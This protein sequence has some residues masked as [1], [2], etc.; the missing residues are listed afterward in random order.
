MQIKKI[1]SIL[2]SCV[3]LP[4]VYSNDKSLQVLDEVHEQLSKYYYDQ[5]IISEKWPSIYNECR[6]K[7]LDAANSQKGF[8]VIKKALEKLK[9]SH[10]HLLTPYDKKELE[11]ME[12]MTFS[13]SGEH[14]FKINTNGQEW[15]L[16]DDKSNPSYMGYEVLEVNGNPL[17]GLEH[18][19]SDWSKLKRYMDSYESIDL[20]LKK[21][22]KKRAIEI[23]RTKISHNILKRSIGF[24]DYKDRLDYQLINEVLV[25]RVEI[26]TISVIQK[27]KKLIQNNRNTKGIVLDLRDNPGGMGML[28][29]ALALEFAKED[30]SLGSQKGG[31]LE[32]NYVV[33][34]QARYYD[35]KVAVIINRNSASTSEI[36]ARGLQ[37]QK[38]ARLFGERTAGMALPSVIKKLS[39]DCVFQYPIGDFLDESGELLEGK[40]VEP[41]E[42]VSYSQE[43]LLSGIDAQ[44]KAALNWIRSH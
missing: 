25:L 9:V 29:C 6:I 15:L 44:L 13:S 11:W 41:D 33:V 20:K 30:F 1:I 14:Y 4:S 18:N 12:P 42:T 35:R 16:S 36:L 19:L 21:P 43:M 26:F 39:Y 31:D 2:F 27:A 22:N 5:K 10:L 3:V 32:M 23:V 17:K 7:C 40:G 38:R 24:I 8:K 37:V 34:K 28:A